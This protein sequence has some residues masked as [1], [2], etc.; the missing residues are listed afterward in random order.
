MPAEKPQDAKPAA[1][2]K[3]TEENLYDLAEQGWAELIAAV[4]KIQSTANKLKKSPRSIDGYDIEKAIV[5]HKPE[6]MKKHLEALRAHRKEN[7]L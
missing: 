3:K 2:E 4:E 7:D 5:K 6:L 1:P